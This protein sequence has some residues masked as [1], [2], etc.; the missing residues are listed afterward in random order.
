MY[1]DTNIDSC[2]DYCIKKD[3]LSLEFRIEKNAEL[4]ICGKTRNKFPSTSFLQI[5]KMLIKKAD[6][7]AEKKSQMKK[8]MW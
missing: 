1:I 3:C 2:F 5:W 7:K 6:S 8:E 4:L